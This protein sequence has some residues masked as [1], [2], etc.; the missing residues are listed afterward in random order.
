LQGGYEN[1]EIA[2][3]YYAQAAKLNP[4]NIRAV[5]GLILVILFLAFLKTK[6]NLLFISFRR[7]FTWL[8][9]QSARLRRKKRVPSWL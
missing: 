1:L 3:S 4:N 9:I 7:R 8:Q 5:Y 2:R 6:L